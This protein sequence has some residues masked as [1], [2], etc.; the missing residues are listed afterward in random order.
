[1]QIKN[2]FNA[3]ASRISAVSVDLRITN[4]RAVTYVTRLESNLKLG[5]VIAQRASPDDV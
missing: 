4:S 5:S 3:H 2:H 1:M